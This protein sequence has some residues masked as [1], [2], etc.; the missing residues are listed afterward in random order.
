MSVSDLSDDVRTKP[1][2]W[3]ARDQSRPE[4]NVV[5]KNG[6]T[7][8]VAPQ[9]NGSIYWRLVLNQEGKLQNKRERFVHSGPSLSKLSWRTVVNQRKRERERQTGRQTGTESK[10]LILYN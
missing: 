8:S 9:R 7:E 2:K 1:R 4:E 6:V 10:R 5:K 3:V